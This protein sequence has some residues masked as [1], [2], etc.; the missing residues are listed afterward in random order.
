MEMDHTGMAIF[1]PVVL[2]IAVFRVEVGIYTQ[3]DTTNCVNE[4]NAKVSVTEGT[5]G[6]SQNP[7][8][9]S[10]STDL[11]NEK[12]GG[13]AKGNH[14]FVQLSIRQLYAEITTTRF[15]FLR[16]NSDYMASKL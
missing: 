11:Q 3:R 2:N 1:Q 7:Y 10:S 15:V 14:T 13:N 16:L 5:S 4:S 9:M 12:C 8:A 6:R